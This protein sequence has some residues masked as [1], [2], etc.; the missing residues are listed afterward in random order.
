MTPDQIGRPRNVSARNPA[1][2]TAVMDATNVPSSITP[3]P[4]ESLFSGSN[5]GSSPYFDG[6]NNAPCVLIRKTAA[7]SIVKFPAAS[8]AMAKSP[9]PIS[10]SFVPIVTVRLL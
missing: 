4:Q 3:F 8:A 2:I 1:N 6:P 5:S 7:A 10:K 9:T